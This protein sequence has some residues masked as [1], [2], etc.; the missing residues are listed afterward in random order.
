MAATS[1]TRAPSATTGRSSAGLRTGGIAAIVFAVTFVI[2][3]LMLSDTPDGNA[4]NQEWRN[5]FLDSG[6][7]RQ[8][9]FGA[10]MLTLAAIAFL[11]FLGVLR[12]R[13]RGAA[14][15]S[16]WIATIT[17]ASG[18]VFVA[19]LAVF[20]LGQGSVAAS[21]VFGDAP[22]PRDAD[23][24]RTFVSAGFGA[25]LL[26]GATSAGLLIFTT[27]IVSGRAALLPRW[28]VVSGYVAAVIVFLGGLLFVPLVLFLLWMLAV[29]IVMLRGSGAAATG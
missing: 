27:S 13:L 9:V 14:P 15:A 6:H 25:L 17:F 16:E 4:S 7:R 2:G 26:F 10:I 23:I 22:V 21:V 28:L 20:A 24:M 8:L 1:T 11:V 29:G 3:F 12:E 19:M 18:V 5:Y